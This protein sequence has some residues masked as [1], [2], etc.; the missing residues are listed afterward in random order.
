MFQPPNPREDATRDD[1]GSTATGAAG[2]TPTS[3]S[4]NKRKSF[5]CS[6][7]KLLDFDMIL[8]FYLLRGLSGEG[9]CLSH[10]LVGGNIYLCEVVMNFS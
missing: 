7:D 4:V 5:N 10:L 6:L 3:P 2:R 1:D 9:W 8:Y